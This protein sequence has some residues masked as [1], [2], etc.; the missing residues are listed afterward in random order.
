MTSRFFELPRTFPVAIAGVI[1]AILAWR[2]IVTGVDA[3]QRSSGAT[4]QIAAV[5]PLATQD[6]EAAW[7]RELARNPADYG[8]LLTLA[9]QAEADG[10][11]DAAR[12]AANQVLRLAPTDSVVLK[13]TA[14]MFLRAGDDASALRILRRLLEFYPPEA[15]FVFPVFTAALDSGR[16]AD[17]FAAAAREDKSWWLGYFMVACNKAALGGLQSVFMTRVRAGITKVSEQRCLLDRLQQEGKWTTAYDYWLSVLPADRRQRIGLVFN[18]GF[19]FPISNLGFDWLTPRQD[20]VSV[21]TEFTDGVTDRRALHVKFI[22][23][24]YAGPPVQQYLQITPGRYQM[25]GRGRADGLSS[26]LG[27][28]WG[29]YCRDSAGDGRQLAHS[30]PLLGSSDWTE[31]RQDFSVSKDCPVQ[32]LRLEL[33]NPRR[34]AK[35]AGNVSVRLRGSVWF[36]DLKVRTLD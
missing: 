23:K 21:S 16:H 32:I 20:D 17:F 6:P 25:E 3:Y 27:V 26:W 9:L 1:A 10:K 11:S 34:D 18:G 33:S 36:D 12:E 19:E 35:V 2:I 29:L 28:Q 5:S 7:R 24:R 13:Q 30:D 31:F 4:G 15:D 8:A 14:S 22:N